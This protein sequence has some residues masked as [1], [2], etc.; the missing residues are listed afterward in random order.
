MTTEI[1]GRA[2]TRP[3]RRSAETQAATSSSLHWQRN[4]PLFKALG[5]TANAGDDVCATRRT[6]HRPII[7]RLPESLA[8]TVPVS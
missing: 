8:T 4:F 2:D 3:A 5:W 7:P 1:R 6:L